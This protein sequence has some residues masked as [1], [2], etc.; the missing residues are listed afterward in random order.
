MGPVDAPQAARD[1]MTRPH[2]SWAHAY[3][4]IYEGSFGAFYGE[5]TSATLAC[6]RELVP[7]PARV[8]DFGAGTGRLAI[9]L[10]LEGH[11]VTAVE[12]SA[13]ML[14]R[15][16]EK[17]AHAGANV[18]A[19]QQRMQEPLDVRG[20]TLAL[21]VFTVT[22]YLLDE[23]ALRAACRTAASVLAPGGLLLIDVPRPE[24]F[25]DSTL[26]VPGGTR[27]VA[28]SPFDDTGTLFT[29][30]EHTTIRIGTEAVHVRDRFPIRCWCVEEVLAALDEAG[31]VQ[32][33][34]LSGRFA[35]TGAQYF[36]C[37]KR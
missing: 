2:D 14:A 18:D 6:V 13:A 5:L 12:P 31:L 11:A 22:L 1:R 20:C 17:A 35:A 33:D 23:E 37:R 30:D 3:D 29:Y 24:M 4:A 28:I 16:R 32:H 10:A 21:C 15:L 19:R 8:V 7:R 36:V 25:G 34:D 27:R 9:P 26:D